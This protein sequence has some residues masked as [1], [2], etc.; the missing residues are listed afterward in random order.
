[1][2]GFYRKLF[3]ILIIIGAILAILV[4]LRQNDTEKRIVN[5][6]ENMAV[7]VPPEDVMDM[8]FLGNTVFAGGRDGIY[9]IKK[10]DGHYDVQ[11]LDLANKATYVRA[12][13]VVD[14]K[15]WIGFDKGLV[16]YD[17]EKETEKLMN[18]DTSP[19]PDDRVNALY[20]DSAGRIWIGTWEGAACIDNS[21]WRYITQDDGLLSNMVNVI[22][23]DTNGGMWFGSYAVR[24]G[25]VSCLCNGKWQYFSIDNGLANNNITDIIC[26]S[27]NNVLIGTGFYDKGGL[28][29]FDYIKDKWQLKKI[30]HPSDGL[31]G[32]KTRSLF[33]DRNGTLYIGSEYSGLTIIKDGNIQILT[34]NDGL[35]HNEIKT[36]N[37][38]GSGNIWLGTRH[39][40]TILSPSIADPE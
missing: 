7:L 38:D 14:N 36:I 29:F 12:L 6:N 8:A 23:E 40:I 1:M 28:S 20:Q 19:L 4:I 25:G 15:L 17:I 21:K 18:K 5:T 39:G 33:Q 27:E 37:R 30:M 24:K 35:S 2:N 31:A 13:L 3:S 32:E 26:S 9:I 16:I 22:A 11:T 10:T 34:E